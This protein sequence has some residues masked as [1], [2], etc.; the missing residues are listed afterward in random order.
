MKALRVIL[1][2]FLFIG[3]IILSRAQV[4]HDDS[5]ALS[6][7]ATLLPQ[8]HH[9]DV[10]GPTFTLDEIDQLAL[11]ANPEIRVAARRLAVVEAHV[12]SAGGWTIR[13][14]CTEAGR[15]LCGSLGTTTPHKTCSWSARSSLG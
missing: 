13:L 3:A 8:H 2:L 1:C 10:L 14:S 5:D 4:P 7:V 12:P 15:F 11:A 6:G 9:P